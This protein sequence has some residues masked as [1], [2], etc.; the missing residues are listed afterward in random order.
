MAFN[1]KLA[2]IILASLLGE[3]ALVLLTTVAQEVLFDGIDYYHSSLGDI[4]FGGLAT[5]IAAVLAGIIASLVVRGKSFVPHIVITVLISLEMTYLMATGIVDGPF[6]FDVLSGLS[7]V[8]GIWVGHY[9][10][11]SFIFRI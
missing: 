1:K 2:W 9:A 6:W 5:F 11:Q 7:L 10:S 4:F 3:A 8:V